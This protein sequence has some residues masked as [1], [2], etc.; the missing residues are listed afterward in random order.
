M[1]IVLIKLNVSLLMVAINSKEINKRIQ[2]IKQSN[3]EYI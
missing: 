2:N 3:V 1:E